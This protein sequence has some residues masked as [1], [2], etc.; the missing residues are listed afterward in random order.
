MEQFSSFASLEGVFQ[1]LDFSENVC[2]NISLELF[3]IDNG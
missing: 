2:T 1:K 3:V